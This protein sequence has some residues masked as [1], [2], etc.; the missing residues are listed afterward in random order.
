MEQERFSTKQWFWVGLALFLMIGGGLATLDSGPQSPRSGTPKV[1]GAMSLSEIDFETLKG[2]QDGLSARGYKEGEDVVYA[3]AQ[4]PETI[5]RLDDIARQH[6][7][8][9]I[10]LL[11][12]SSTPATQAAQ[13][14]TADTQIPVIFAP[15]SSPLDAGVVESL[16]SPGGNITGIKLPRSDSV[17][18]RWLLRI[19]PAVKRVYVP[20]TPRDKSAQNTLAKI[21]SAA[22]LASVQLV[23][24]PVTSSQQAADAARNLPANIDAIFLPRDSLIESLIIDFVNSSI[25]RKLPLSAPARQ[26]LQQGAL[27]FY[28]HVHEK[29]GLQAAHIADQILRGALPS[30]LPVEVGESFLGV[31]LQ[32]AAKIGLSIP[33][34]VLRAADFIIYPASTSV[35]GGINQ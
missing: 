19:A 35:T 28:G 24:A 33:E 30:N 7:E 4:P 9:H 13:K 6:V 2:F 15:V 14:A 31:N 29:L 8:N 23:L 34:D 21:Q 32:T 11:F 3:V 17:R 10:D 27:F 5:D 18:F 20:Y 25:E 1:I 16:Q 22:D 12:V 26:Q